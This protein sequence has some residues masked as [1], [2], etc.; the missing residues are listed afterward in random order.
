MEITERSFGDLPDG[1]KVRHFT[2]DNGKGM[3]VDIIN[4]GGIV[5]AIRIPGKDRHPGDIVLGFDSLEG[6]LGEHPYFGGIIGRFANRIGRGRFTL[7]GREYTLE[8]NTGKNHLHG[9]T[10]GFDKVLWDAA[11][12]KSDDSVTLRLAYESVH[13]EEGYPGNLS[14]E[15]DYLLNG[16]NELCIE[17]R[18]ISDRATHVNLTNHSYFNFNNCEGDILGHELMID[19]DRVTELDADSIPTGRI[20]DVN[21]TCF[22]FRVEKPIGKDL[23]ETEPGYDI[24][25]VVNGY[26]SDLQRIASV[27]HAGTG[28]SMDVLTTEP[29]VQLYTSNYIDEINGKEGKVYRK[30]G[31]LCLETQH[32]PDS[33]NKPAFPSTRL[34]P[35]REYK[36]VTIYRFRW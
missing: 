13:M 4:L 16:R 35:G 15:V 33:P 28:R 9:G 36:Q 19:A 3:E 11:T 8:T 14:V 22:D 27:Y 23:H 5:R 12:E 31:A 1:R 18:A 10:V 7:D 6:Y 24:N 30:H 26:S 20:V 2:L 32:F 29:G 17:Y 34:D 25:F 21:G